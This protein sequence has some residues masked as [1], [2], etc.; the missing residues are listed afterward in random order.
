L[1]GGVLEELTLLENEED[2]LYE[3]DP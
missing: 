2:M 1:L 3:N